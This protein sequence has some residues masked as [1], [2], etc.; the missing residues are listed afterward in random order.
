ME[1]MTAAATA[2]AGKRCKTAEATEV[3]VIVFT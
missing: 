2:V 3:A 1:E